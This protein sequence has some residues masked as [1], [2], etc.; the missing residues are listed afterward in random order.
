MSHDRDPDV[1]VED[2][3]SGL[4]TIIGVIA[5]IA[6]VAAIWWFGF[7]PGQ[8]TFGGEDTAPDVDVD[9]NVPSVV[10]PS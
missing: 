3:G 5:I 7:G 8:G 2:R 6:L 10:V 1:V 9:V 4:G